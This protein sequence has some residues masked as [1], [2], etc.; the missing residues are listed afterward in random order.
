MEQKQAWQITTLSQLLVL[1]ERTKQISQT[2][3]EEIREEEEAKMLYSHRN[4]Q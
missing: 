3:T 2:G 1:E 4:S